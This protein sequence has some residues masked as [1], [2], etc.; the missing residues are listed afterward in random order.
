MR[1]R[2]SQ[3]IS[4]D[5]VQSWVSSWLSESVALPDHGWKCTAAVVWML[6]IRAA[7]RQQSISAACRDLIEIH[8]RG[9]LPILVGGTGF[10]YRALTRGLF[11]GPGADER[12]RSRLERA[13]AVSD[14]FQ[15]RSHTFVGSRSRK[16]SARQRSVIEPGPANE[17]RQ[18]PS[19]VYLTSK[20]GRIAGEPGRRVDLRRFD[21][22]DEMVGNSA[23]LVE[24]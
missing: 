21:N 23:S 15:P 1:S 12:L 9:R 11:P 18:T 13:S 14:A 7:A 4:S 19:R 10:Y 8:A 20:P 5:E 2:K 22:V 24:G 17:N 16:Q 3:T 6:L